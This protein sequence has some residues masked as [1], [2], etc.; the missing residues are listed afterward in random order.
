M[1]GIVRWLNRFWNVVT[2]SVDF[3][4]DAKSAADLRAAT[5]R[6]IRSVTD[7]IEAFRF[8][9]LIARLMEFTST[10]ARAR[11]EGAVDRQAWSEAV[12][13]LMRMAAP[14]APHIAEELWDRSGRRYSVHQQPWPEF[15]AALAVTANVKIVIQVNGKVRDHIEVEAGASQDTVVAAAIRSDRIAQL[16]DGR[17]PRN[18]IYV[19]GRLVNV[20]V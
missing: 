5:H 8:N 14:L 17:E 1:P 9:T 4:D 20:V 7:D 2:A 16:L 15:D 13:A 6:T 3:V 12:D 18:V 11:D 10:L 19:P